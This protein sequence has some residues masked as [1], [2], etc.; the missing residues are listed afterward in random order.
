MT[1]HLLILS[2]IYTLFAGLAPAIA[3]TLA[4]PA[5]AQT[6]SATLLPVADAWI[7]E[8]SAPTNY[9]DD[10]LLYTG[11][12]G[13]AGRRFAL[14]RFDLSSL[15]VN[16]EIISATLSLYKPYWTTADHSAA[17]HPLLGDWDSNAVSWRVRR[18]DPWQP[19]YWQTPG[20]LGAND[21][22]PAT[23][24]Q[25]APKAPGWVRWDVT[26]SAK[27]WARQPASN[28]GLLLAVTSDEIV[29]WAS[30]E[31]AEG[32]RPRLV[33]SYRVGAAD[34]PPQMQVDAPLPWQEV[35][36]TVKISAQ[37]SDDRGVARVELEANS[38]P[39]ISISAPPYEFAWDAQAAAA[40]S[41]LS[42]HAL[43][44]GL[45]ALSDI[46]ALPY[47]RSGV[48]AHEVSSRDPHG[49]NSDLDNYLYRRG[50][51]YVLLDVEGPG[52]LYNL[53]FTSIPASSRLRIYF[54]GEP[55]PRVDMEA[56]RFFGGAQ[57]PFLA[58]L[59][60]DERASSG[61]YYCFLPMPFARSCVVACL[62]PP[63]YYHIIYHTYASAEGVQTFTGQ[64]DISALHELWTRAGQDPKDTTG[65]RVL[66]GELIIPRGEKAALAEISGA[67]VIQSLRLRPSPRTPDALNTV[68]LRCYWD[69]ES[70]PSVEAPLGHFFGSGL[71]EASVRGLLFGMSAG[72]DYYC[73]F[74][75]P[76]WEGARLELWNGSATA[77]SLRYEA[78]YR[79]SPYPRGQA[80]YF[81]ARYQDAQLSAD[82][83]DYVILQSEGQGHFVGAVLTMSGSQP[84]KPSYLEGD[85]RVYI[86]GSQSPSLYGTGTEDYFLGGWYFRYDTFTLPT[87]GFPA[88]G[89]D[90]Q[91]HLTCYR[92]H[93]GDLIPYES[94]IRFGIEHG[95]GN[96]EAAR[97]RSLAFYYQLDQPG[98]HLSDEIAIGDPASES[99]HGYAI[100]VAQAYQLAPSFDAIRQSKLESSLHPDVAQA[101]QPAPSFDAIH[102]SELESSLYVDPFSVKTACY[103]GDWDDLPLRDAGRVI[104]GRVEFEVAVSPLNRGVRLRRRRDQSL[105]QQRALVYVDGAL[106]GVW[107][108]AAWNPI[109][110]WSDETFQLPPA[111]TRGKSRLRIALE[112]TDGRWNEYHYW[113]ESLDDTLP[114]LARAYDSA[115]QSAEQTIRVRPVLP[116]PPTA[117]PTATPTST[118]SPT[119]T[120]TATTTFTA[121]A[122]ASPT[123]TE[124][125]TFTPTATD[126]ATPSPTA[127][128]TETA[129]P[130]PSPRRFYLPLILRDNNP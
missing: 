114:L 68:W 62:L 111:L 84:G 1:K 128:E 75:M 46:A 7:N 52:C 23:S 47:L 127:T 59:V 42:T 100:S 77:L 73:Y 72:G 10:A 22:D 21:R 83:S 78:Q 37:A 123:P 53:W 16:A 66:S 25:T 12:Q 40:Q 106:T 6:A 9:A 55:T 74:P 31:A 33:L 43:P 5:F 29:R 81:H 24:T 88:R 95:G 32:Q 91:E 107:Y 38:E 129:T 51:E 28:R 108:S 45:P 49:K 119:P 94:A 92:L 79:E 65:N 63:R 86:D 124:T 97:Y 2:L 44:V 19:G 30:S 20:A 121:T 48:Q 93:L 67:G 116:P 101:Y 85:E 82:G 13:A 117:T 26:T 41:R 105:G 15:P 110:G 8:W 50:D 39:P 98:L 34:A 99:A 102:Q 113:V 70:T 112:I 103:E 115:G 64:E 60:G 11:Q 89:R 69:S 120:E 56:A 27:G 3:A 130:T 96:E 4:A 71:G 36:G 125:A 35:W 122:T 118:P 61:G 57:F 54:D 58:P 109:K 17:L 126:T 80:G 18:V 104:N 90:A 87:H 76:Y 14:L